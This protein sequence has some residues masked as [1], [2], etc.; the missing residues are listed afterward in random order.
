MDI[1]SRIKR[2]ENAEQIRCLKARY[3]D[4]CDEGYDAEALVALFTPDAVWDGGDL[5]V[6]EGAERIHQFFANMPNVMSFAIHHITNSAIEVAEDNQ[7]AR[8][9]WYL[10]QAATLNESNQ[11]VWLTGCYDDELIR[12]ASGWKFKRVRLKSRFFSPY[13]EGW[14]ATPF[15]EVPNV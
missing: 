3:C 8:G 5:G 11:A 2:V 13:E 7:S 6:F 9:R 10:L 1:E 4:L 14:A 15:M 12:D